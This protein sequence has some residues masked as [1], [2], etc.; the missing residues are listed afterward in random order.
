LT[1]VAPPYQLKTPNVAQ[2]DVLNVV[3]AVTVAILPAL[4]ERRYNHGKSS[5]TKMF[6]H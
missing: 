2:L 3:A 4:T 5:R 1:F 6:T